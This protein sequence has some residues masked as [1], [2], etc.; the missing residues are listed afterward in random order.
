[1]LLM[2][3]HWL[4]NFLLILQKFSALNFEFKKKNDKLH[5]LNDFFDKIR[6]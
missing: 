3:R 1:M 2:F 4:I 5:L 6:S